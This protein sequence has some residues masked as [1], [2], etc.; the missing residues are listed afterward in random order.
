MRT[1][2]MLLLIACAS[3]V[4]VPAIRAE[5]KVLDKPLWIFP[6]QQFR[7]CLEQPAGSGELKVEVPPTLELF[8]TWDQDA[9]Q[10]YYFRSLKPGDATLRFSGKGGSMEMP[11]EV[12]AWGDVYAPREYKG[13][14]LPRMWPMNDLDFSE[15]KTRRTMH[16]E[17]DLEELRAKGKVEARAKRWLEA[18]DEEIY[19]IIPGPSVPRTCLMV[20]GSL[21][22][23]N[24]IGKGCPVC[25][26]KIYEGRSGFYPWQYNNQPQD[27][28][29]RCPECGTVFPSNDWRNGDMH[30]GPFPDDG[31]GCEPVNAP[32]AADGGKWRWPF[33]AYYHQWAAYM[34]EFTP[35]IINTAEAFAATGDKAYAH[36]CAIALL[37]YSEAMV[38]MSLNLNHRKMANRNGV[39]KG[40]VGAPVESQFDKLASSFSYVQPNWD[41][42]RMENCARAWDLI[43]DQLDDDRE[44]IEFCQKHSHPDIKTIPDF[45]RFIEAGV[46]RTPIQMGMDNAVSRN[47]P[48]QEIMIANTA[49]CLGTEGTT[50]VADWLLNVNGIR[51]ALTNMFYKDGSA[52]E[53]PS[54]NHGHIRNTADI[55]VA[56]GKLQALH[57]EV[58]RP[59][60]FVSVTEDR[61]FRR[62]YDFPLECS[63]IGRTIPFVGDAGKGGPS[64][65]L[66]LRQG[67]PC[68]LN[69]WMV[70]YRATGD[71]R[72]AQAMYG[73]AGT[74]AANID[75]PQLKAAA[76]KAG[77]ELGW[78][79]NVPSNMLDGYGFAILRSGEGDNER[80]VWMRYARNLQHAHSD[81]LTYG[82]AAL[83]REL[84]PELGYPEGWTYSGHWESN[85]G[86]HYGTKITGLRTTNFSKA[87]LTTFVGEPPAQVA[88]AETSAM[89]G[90]QQCTRQRVIALVDLSPTDFYIVTAERVRGGEEHTF[91]FHGPD[92]EVTAENL[93]LDPYKGT[94][95]GEGL[96]YADFS[97]TKHTDSEFSCLGLMYDPARANPQGVWGLDYLLRDQDNVHLRMTSVYPEGGEL[98]VAKG[99]P[100]GGRKL[101]EMT[102]AV[103]RNRG[104][105]PLASQYVNVLEPYLAEPSIARIERVPVT[106]GDDGSPFAPLALRVTTRDS[107]DTIILQQQAGPL[108]TADGIT[109]DGEFCL[110]R[111][112]AGELE[113]ATLVRGT[114]LLRSGRGIAMDAAEYTG[115]IVACD[116]TKSAITVR[117]APPDVSALAG[118]HIRITNHLG[119]SA[120]CQIETAEAVADGCRI[121]FNLDPRIGEGFVQECKD[122]VVT[123]EI[124]LRLYPYGY[125]DGKTLTN[126]TGEVL[127]RLRTVDRSDCIIAQESGGDLSAAT[128]Q[129]QFGDLDGDGLKRFVIYDYGPGDAVTMENF[130]VVRTHGEHTVLMRRGGGTDNVTIVLNRAKE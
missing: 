129:K 58:C 33:I 100:P 53:S 126:E 75:D 36:K 104:N 79:V 83:K 109:C 37:R 50:E 84:L 125:Y 34:N 122:G 26:T 42:P 108:L 102:W 19:N 24:G 38:D 56:L 78:Q 17:V 11:L 73:P 55:S 96:E 8:D 3:L 111:E 85:W 61:K 106:G 64:G 103:L 69:D 74:L 54:Y 1:W 92:G 77:E 43:F 101:Y 70:A 95:L 4:C 21:E 99:K 7:V 18:P 23:N 59:P 105:A 6:G 66:P 13:V 20:L 31:Y 41:T 57:P 118:R 52:Y 22:A 49:L 32:T 71:P 94:G 117:P 80:A 97:P 44:L 91:S 9:I 81:M 25:G 47:W 130:A 10:R 114:K 16:S 72:F 124:Y 48:Q 14:K 46:V 76:V 86:T 51:F 113:S 40:P 121:T 45:R 107:V 5:L 62:L 29:V 39:Y 60:R 30:S 119:S 98:T 89:L 120:S 68:D 35:G 27:W 12:L 15:L 87:E 115:E 67:N 127:H 110:W 90:D 93:Q 128:L 82:I 123:S 28:K 88:V 63:L 116:W 65:V 112:C 2:Q